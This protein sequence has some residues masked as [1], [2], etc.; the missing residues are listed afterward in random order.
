MDHIAGP[1]TG[2]DAD[3]PDP[4]SSRA[5]YRVNIGNQQPVELMT[6]ISTIE[7]AWQGSEEE[8]PADAA[9]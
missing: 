7:S 3:H 9:R 4:G 8:F 1:N 5:P 6:F 2:F